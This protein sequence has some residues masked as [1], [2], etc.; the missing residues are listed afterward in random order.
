MKHPLLIGI[1]FASAF[2]SVR[3]E[4]FVLVS[5][6]RNE[7]TIIAVGDIMLGRYVEELSLRKGRNYPFASTT[8]I[9]SGADVVFGNLEG[10]VPNEHEKTPNYGWRFSFNKEAVK[11]ARRAGINVV[12]LANNH[13]TDFGGSGYDE[14]VSSLN[15]IGIVSVGKHSDYLYEKE[16]IKIRFMGWNDT[17]APLSLKTVSDKIRASKKENEFLIAAVHFG[18]EYA[19]SSTSRQKELARAMIDAGADVVIGS[20]PHVVEEKE[21]YH[22]KPIF[23][24]LGNFI[25][26]QYFSEETQKGL[27]VKMTITG[28]TVK[29][30][31]MPISLHKSR[32]QLDM[33][34]EI[35]SFSLPRVK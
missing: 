10:T 24:S 31:M 12:T 23:Y 29:Y 35:Q 15:D 3:K 14:T 22:E 17:F 20:H 33:N 1:I 11:E 6:S 9:F 5:P 25:F 19:T 34:A 21:I 27:A 8:K 7:A 16:G 2:F 26:D 4:G 30:E 32:P 28:S 13:S 18:E